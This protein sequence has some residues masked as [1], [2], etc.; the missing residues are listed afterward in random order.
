MNLND[1]AA[2]IHRQNEKWWRDLRTGEPL[3]RNRGEMLMLIV[4]EIAE[5][6]EGERKGL[7]DNHLPHRRMAEV[8][9]A[10]AMIRILD[11]AAGHGYDIHGALMEKLIYNMKRADHQPAARMAAGGKKW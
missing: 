6:M 5:A 2:D 9:L 3:T 1:L 11:Y 7:M 10:D 8:E 4:S